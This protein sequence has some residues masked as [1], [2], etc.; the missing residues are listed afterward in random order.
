[1]KKSNKHTLNLVFNQLNNKSKNGY[2]KHH[3]EKNY[4]IFENTL[5]FLTLIS[6]LFAADTPIFVINRLV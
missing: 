2:Q 1:M 3:F 6:P 4:V 5:L